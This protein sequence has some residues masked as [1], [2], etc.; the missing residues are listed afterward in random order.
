MFHQ[1]SQNFCAIKSCVRCHDRFSEMPNFV[2]NALNLRYSEFGTTLNPTAH[3]PKNRGGDPALSDCLRR[4]FEGQCYKALQG[5]SVGQQD[6]GTSS[7][8]TSLHDVVGSTAAS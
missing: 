7:H 3:S 8:S 5:N 6:R 4:M 1:F 2:L